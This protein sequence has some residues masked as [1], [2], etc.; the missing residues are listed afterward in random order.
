MRRHAV[1]VTP[2]GAAI[3]A[4]REAHRCS[5]R[6]L[7]EKAGINPSYLSQI[8]R[9]QRDPRPHTVHL[10]AQALGVQPDAISCPHEG[11]TTT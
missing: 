11:T 5:L 1:H 10:I 3:R 7:A 2:N 6:D 4:I 9:G 8:E